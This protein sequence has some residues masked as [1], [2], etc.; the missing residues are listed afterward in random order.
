MKIWNSFGSAHSANLT[1]VGEFKREANIDLA[2]RIIRDFV[3]VDYEKRYKNISEFYDTWEPNCAPIR[4][5]GPSQ[6]DI[7]IGVEYPC[8][9][10]K[11][12]GKITVSDIRDSNIGGIIKLMLLYDPIEI[13]ITGQTGP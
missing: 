11:K 9:V 2:E 1:I 12:D 10:N 8:N 4:A 5:L 3:N 13:K 6:Y 7:Q